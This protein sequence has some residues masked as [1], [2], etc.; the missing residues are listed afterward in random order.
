MENCI[1]C[2][3]IAGEIPS[4]KVYEDDEV[5]A[6]LDITPVNF[7]HTLV[8]PKKHYENLVSL[9]EE[10]AE[11]VFAVAKKIA[12][13]ITSGVGA[14]GFN[15]T[16]NNGP[17]AGQAVGHVHFHIIPRFSGDGY[18]LWRGK[19]YPAGKAGEIAEK[20]KNQI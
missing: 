19:E 16:L 5:L 1:F 10:L 9:P 15:L 20:I 4:Y 2:K 12:P 11:K 8:I 18:E 14:E 6:F 13:A 7:G 17:V 3:I